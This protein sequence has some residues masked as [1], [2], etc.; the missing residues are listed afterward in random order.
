MGAIFGILNFDGAPASLGDLDRMSRVLTHRGAEATA[1]SDGPVA[2]GY[3]ATQI[4]VEDRHDRQPV[5]AP[6]ADVTLVA[7]VRLD[8]RADLAAA[9]A[10]DA[11]T[12]RGLP[13]SALVLRAYLKWG[14]R[15]AEQLLG[16]F[17][18][19][20]WDGRARRLLLARDHMGQRV[21]FYHLG[22]RSLAFASEIKGLWALPDV[23]VDIDEATIASRL[24]RFEARRPGATLFAGVALL[25]GGAQISVG[26]RGDVRPRTYWTP[27][28]APAHENRD[29]AYYAEAYRSVLAEA[30]ACRLRRTVAP[31]ALLLSGGFDSSAIAG[32]AGPV[33]TAQDRKLVAVCSAMGPDYAGTIRHAR[34]WAELCARDMPHLDLR[35][36]T[37]EGLS[38]IGGLEG[39]FHRNDG[40]GS[41]HYVM[42]SLYAAAAEAGA[43]VI[44]DGYGGDQTLN[45]R[46]DTALAHALARGEVARF[47]AEFRAHLRVSGDGIWDAVRLSLAPLAPAAARRAWRRV[48]GAGGASRYPVIA[49]GF[50]EELV[51]T[52]RLEPAG[53]RAPV[54]PRARMLRGLERR[55]AAA[56]AIAAAAHGLEPAEPFFDKRVVE[57]ALAIPP[58]L[59]VVRGRNR[60]LARRA[61]A[62]VYPPEFQAR[63]RA[64]DDLAPDFQRMAAS[65]QPE[66]LAELARMEASGRLARYVDLAEVRRLLTARGPDDH[67]SGWEVETQLALDAFVTARLIEWIRRSND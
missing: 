6:E 45:P 36:V 21:P 14:E 60:H 11:P 15:C 55:R 30:V 7:D 27:A 61:L 54:D 28:A 64:N 20:V 23:P 26:A 1:W 10:I 59:H 47:A 57:L 39:A 25:T 24:T 12:L 35:Y 51:A 16:D 37:R 19:A 34:R 49:P 29:E 41:Y 67:N 17:A 33:V 53:G 2:L 8:N 5:H 38:V 65:I 4:T 42:D 63:G 62:D 46:G 9:L 40:T 32:L 56:G 48:R 52:G 44:L 58:H 43:G 66:V 50:L 18:F 3:R 22:E 31:A 13:D